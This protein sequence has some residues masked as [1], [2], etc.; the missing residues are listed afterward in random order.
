MTTTATCRISTI[1][2]SNQVG[3]VAIK[4]FPHRLI[5]KLMKYLCTSNCIAAIWLNLFKINLNFEFINS[6]TD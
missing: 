2:T 6:G 1:K 4:V 5:I 3:R